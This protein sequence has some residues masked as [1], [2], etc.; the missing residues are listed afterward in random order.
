MDER[1]L[2]FLLKDWKRV[3]RAYIVK[4]K[5]KTKKV[6][7]EKIGQNESFVSVRRKPFS[8]YFQ[9]L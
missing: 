5:N 6:G 1:I 9:N 2:Y 8:L 4:K 3:F 7:T